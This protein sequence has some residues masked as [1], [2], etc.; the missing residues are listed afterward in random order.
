MVAVLVVATL[1][2]LVGTLL[3]CSRATVWWVRGFDFP[4]LQLTVF[5]LLLLIAHLL[6]LPL[7]DLWAW[8]L[9]IATLGCLLYQAWWV[10]PYAPFFPREVRRAPRGDAAPRLSLISANVEL[11]NRKAAP[12]LA[13]VERYQPDLVITLESDAWWEEQLDALQDRYPHA[14]KC[15]LDNAYGMHVYSRLPLE[16]PRI[17]FLVNPEVPSMHFGLRLPGGQE[18]DVHCVHPMP[19]SPTESDSS[20]E[21]DAELIAVGYAVRR[22]R[23]P[24]IVAGDLNDVAWSETT[25]LFRK[26]SGLL[27]PRVGRGMFNTFHARLPLFRWP[28]DHLFHSEDFSLVRIRRLR[29]IGS[30]HFPIYAELAVTA[31]AGQSG[32]TA[33]AGDQQQAAG[34]LAEG[35]VTPAAVHRPD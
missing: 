13:L 9:V 35:E 28:I 11:S 14:L 30:D 5:G 19:P 31:P 34:Q 10:L 4:R 21:R 18:V 12:L 29:R 7:T 26:I 23:R 16:D 17:Q 6:L 27:D 2:L 22:R 3:P 8:L 20:A 24:V 32:L 1:L 33:D 25:R 15:P